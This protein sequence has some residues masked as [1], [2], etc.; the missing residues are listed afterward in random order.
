MNR[1]REEKRTRGDETSETRRE[2]HQMRTNEDKR[3]AKKRLL[4]DATEG[5]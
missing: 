1:M 2:E 4:K 5:N 3:R